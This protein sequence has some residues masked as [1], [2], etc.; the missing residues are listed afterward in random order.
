MNAASKAWIPFVIINA[1][2]TFFG[3]SYLFFPGDDVVKAGNVT[4]G[5]LAVPREIW[6]T[7]AVASAV[8][9][10]CV[11]VVGLPLR[12]R[13][14]RV[15]LLYQFVFFAAV[16]AIEPDPVFPTIFSVILALTLWLS[17]PGRPAGRARSA[18]DHQG[19]TVERAVN[20]TTPD[21]PRS[22]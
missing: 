6:G 4:E 2:V 21:Q 20:L 8:A 19:T 3:L 7:F 22:R 16:A 5:V 11:A 17:R 15:T 12:R 1:L 14:A 13:W 18:E 9:M 10:I